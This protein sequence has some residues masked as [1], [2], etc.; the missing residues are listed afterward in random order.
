MEYLTP[1]NVTLGCVAAFALR[2]LLTPGEKLKAPL[3]PG[4]KALP[5]LGNLLDMPPPG[6]HDWVHWAKHKEQYGPLMKLLSP[7]NQRTY[8]VESRADKRSIGLGN[9]DRYNQRLAVRRRASRQEVDYLF[10]Q[11]SDRLWR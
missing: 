11:G 4:P 10:R 9:A 1:V 6:G 8:E 5:V 7:K 3:P 2:R